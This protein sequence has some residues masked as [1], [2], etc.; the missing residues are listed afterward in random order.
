MSRTTGSAG[1]FGA[2]YLDGLSGNDTLV[3]GA[4]ADTMAGGAGNDRFEFSA[5]SGA[6]RV[7][8]FTAGAGVADVLRITGYGAALDSFAEVFAAATQVGADTVINLG[9]ANSITLVG[10]LRTSLAADDFVFG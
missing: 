2:D 1:D 5:G 6:D 9:G 8:D 7:T 10:I 3:G 4:G